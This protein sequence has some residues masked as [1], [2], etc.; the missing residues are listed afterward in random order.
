MVERDRTTCERITWFR[1]GYFSVVFG[2]LWEEAVDKVIV[3]ETL[4][5]V[6]PWWRDPRQDIESE[7]FMSS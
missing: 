3:N 2:D 5:G 7:P 6:G 4:S 1:D